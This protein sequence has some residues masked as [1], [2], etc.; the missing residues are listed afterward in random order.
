[1]QLPQLKNSSCLRT[2]NSLTCGPAAQKSWANATRPHSCWNVIGRMDNSGESVFTGQLLLQ[3]KAILW[4]VVAFCRP[5]LVLEQTG[6]SP[7]PAEPTAI[8]RQC[9]VTHE[10]VCVL[11]LHGHCQTSRWQL[12]IRIANCAM[13]CLI[14]RTCHFPNNGND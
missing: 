11:R 7:C 2:G 10:A 6:L 12:R 4:A 3:F 5:E 1:M 8:Q 14:P 13:G 9:A